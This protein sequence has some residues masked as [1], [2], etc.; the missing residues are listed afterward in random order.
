MALRTTAG[1]GVIDLTLNT[2]GLS[3]GA[4]KVSAVLR[5]TLVA[6]A[7]AATGGLAAVAAAAVKATRAF[8]G[9]EQSMAR[10]KALT[11]A[12][13]TQFEAL[14]RTATRLGRTTIFTARQ[15]AEA[16]GFFAQAG[17]TTNEI[18]GAMPATLNLAA[19]GQL[20]MAE[21][22]DSVTKI[23]RG[24]GIEVDQVEHA[25]NVLTQA[26]I[27]SNTNLSQ[28]TDAMKFIGPVGRAAGIGLEELVSAIQVMSNAGIQGGEAG[29]ALR[30]II[31]NFS[32]TN[33]EAAKVLESLGVEIKNAAGGFRSLADIV[34]EL[35]V[36]TEHMGETQR[37]M[38]FGLIAGARGVA[39][40]SSLVEGGGVQLRT[41]K[42][43]LEDVG[44]VSG[45]VAT[46]QIATLS[47]RFTILKSEVDATAIAFGEKM[48]PAADAMIE[49]IS[50]LNEKFNTISPAVGDV[51][52]DITNLFG[53]FSM[54]WE[55]F[56]D[57]LVAKAA[58]SMASILEDVDRGT[59]A[60][61][62]I[63]RRLTAAGASVTGQVGGAP[64]SPVA[65]AGGLISGGILGGTGPNATAKS[66]RATEAA[67]RISVAERELA[68]AKRLAQQ[69]IDA[70]ASAQR[71][72]KAKME[73]EKL[74]ARNLKL[75]KEQSERVKAA[76]R[77]KSSISRLSNAV[78]AFNAAQGIGATEAPPPFSAIEGASEMFNRI[79]SNVISPNDPE[80][81]LVDL[82]EEAN[83]L[84]KAMVNFLGQ[85]ASGAGKVGQSITG[86]FAKFVEKLVGE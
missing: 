43:N 4:S 84:F 5:T 1:R 68:L 83:E 75:A 10:V 34:D 20:S 41:F 30:R 85:M 61:I 35:Q 56:W 7:A 79:Q 29:T 21:A 23:M 55:N 80:E 45:R 2:V 11:G 32:G 9:F 50:Q 58:G 28:L 67:L 72:A 36:A 86:P 77:G 24:M 78:S 42:K 8:A 3:R 6:A 19:A 63:L 53:N 57:D 40:F 46:I 62:S 15:A 52:F 60:T 65:V 33:K 74:I 59:N 31:L 27:S 54:G 71:A 73:A 26:F 48:Q 13:G 12:V 70:N 44:D 37:T 81:K 47:G 39:G 25:V 76:F 51:L 69:Q 49:T 82:Q 17:L 66:L 18:I 64:G 22:A 38:T 14:N 16:M